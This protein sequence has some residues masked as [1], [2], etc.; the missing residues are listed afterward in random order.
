MSDSNLPQ[1]D[2]HRS[3]GRATASGGGQPARRSRRWLGGLLVLVGLLAVALAILLPRTRPP[4]SR[5]EASS[6]PP[7]RTASRPVGGLLYVAEGAHSG[8]DD[9]WVANPDGTSGRNLTPDRASDADPDWSPDGRRVVYASMPSRCQ[10]PACHQD[11]YAIDRDGHNR[12][13][14]TNTPQDEHDP[15]WSPD[16]TRIAYTRWDQDRPSVWVMAAD[17]SGQRP[18]AND[19]GMDPDWAPDGTQLL[20]LQVG[21]NRRPLYTIGA[22]GSARQRL[23]NLTV[24]RTAR[25]SPDGTRIALTMQDAVWIVSA[26]GSGLQR[27]RQAAVYPSWSPDGRQLVFIAYGT[28]TTG[29]QL[30]RMD[31]DGRNEAVLRR[32]QADSAPKLR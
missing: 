31:A 20:Y 25:W 29:P 15:D 17:G 9:V 30:R 26:N 27:I 1:P 11:L 19:P 6:P 16:G 3:P 18:L 2:H 32:D 8:V 21:S 5:P 4:G 14:L 7:T 28:S 10:G 13:R 22:D 12:V 23:G 24:V